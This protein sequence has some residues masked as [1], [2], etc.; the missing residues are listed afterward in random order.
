MSS[1]PGRAASHSVSMRAI[2]SSS[3]SFWTIVSLSPV[4]SATSW[5][6]SS[7]VEPAATNAVVDVVDPDGRVVTVGS[8]V[9]L[10]AP[11]A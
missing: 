8:I 5:S 10:H 11:N 7:L 1:T 2:S 3:P 9:V 6:S 4:A